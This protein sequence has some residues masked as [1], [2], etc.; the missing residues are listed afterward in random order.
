MN[1]NETSS[2]QPPLPPNPPPPDSPPVIKKEKEDEETSCDSEAIKM[3]NN[4]NENGISGTELAEE[5][6]AKL[7]RETMCRNYIRGTCDRGS[8]CIFVHRVIRSQ[9]K[10][11][12]KF[13]IDFQNPSGCTRPQCKFVHAT[14]FEKENFY[15]TAYL[16]PHTVAHLKMNNKMPPPPNEEVPNE[17]RPVFMNQPPPPIPSEAA[18]VVPPKPVENSTTASLVSRLLSEILKVTAD[19]KTPLKREWNDIDEYFSV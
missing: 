9:L 1:Q 7:K 4:E 6:D 5:D 11:V 14:V 13:C 2:I 10:D 12:Y 17:V 15:K 18:N 19:I 16:P 8:S 3:Q